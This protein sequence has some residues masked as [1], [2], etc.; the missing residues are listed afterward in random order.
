[1]R[2]F[3]EEIAQWIKEAAASGELA[4]AKG[5]G[6]PLEPDAGWDATPEALRMPM[7]I[8]KDAGIAPPEIAMFHERARLKGLVE[9]ASDVTERD[10]LQ[11][12]LVE[13]EQ[14]LALR[15]ESLRLHGL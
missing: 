11:R 2:T 14:K 6:K 5:Y 15:L 4:A 9:A 8:L 7:K 12:E 3:D 1:M 13:L 10:R